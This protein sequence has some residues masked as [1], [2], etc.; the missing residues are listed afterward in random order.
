MQVPT[1]VRLAV[2]QAGEAWRAGGLLIQHMAE[3]QARGGTEE[4]WRTAQS[5]FETVGEDELL[6]PELPGDT[7][8]WRLFHED[9]V[10]LFGAK[11]LKSFCRCSEARIMTVLR[12][13]GPEERAGMVEADGRIRV[14]C[15]YCSRDYRIPPETVDQG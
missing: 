13:F 12:S 9:G 11:P 15:E 2:G 3:D 7:L 10:R 1:R 4:A 8:L 5:L 6:D 14:T